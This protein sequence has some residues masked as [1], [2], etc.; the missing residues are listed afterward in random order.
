SEPFE[1]WIAFQGPNGELVRVKAL[2]DGG[3]GVGAMDKAVWE[4]NAHRLGPLQPSR[5]M[6][7]MANGALV[8]S[9][10]VWTGTIVIEGV[11]RRG[12]FEI[13]DGG[14][15]WQFLFGKPLQTAFGAIHDYARDVI[16]ISVEGAG[17]S[18]AN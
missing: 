12:S 10:G 3:A 1:H 6:L 8:R 2:W 18:L 15:G 5:K 9:K 16:D 14:G 4:K 11:K 7:R 13:L 17:A